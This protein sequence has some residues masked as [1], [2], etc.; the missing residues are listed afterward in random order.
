MKRILSL[1][2]GLC[3]VCP[4][5]HAT[6][7]KKQ[8]LKVLYVGGMTDTY[9]PAPEEKDALIKE[10]TEAFRQ[11]LD[12]YFTSV[13]AVDGNDYTADMSKQY[14]VTI[15]DGRP[16]PLKERDVIKDSQGNIVKYIPAKYLP[17]DFDCATVT[18]GQTGETVGRAIGLKNDWYCLCLDAQA[19]HW[20]KDHP[21]FKGPFKVKMTVETCPTP[22]DAYHYAYYHDGPIPDELPMWRV[23]T[24]GFKTDKGF[25][26]GMV[27]RPWGYTD[28]PDAEYISSGVCAKTLDAVAIGRHGNFLHWGFAASPL[29][30]TD[31]AKTVFANAVAYIAKFKGK[32]VQARK[33]NDRIATRE[34][35]KEIA[36]L[37][38][39]ASYDERMVSDREWHMERVKSYNA[40]IAKKAAGQELSDS[41]KEELKYGDPGE[42]KPRSREEYVKRYAKNFFDMFGTDEEAYAKYFKENYDY[43]YSEGFY[44]IFLD[45]DV[46]AWGIPNYNHRLLDKAITSLEQGNETD[47]AARILARYTMADFKTPAEWRKWYET[48]KD[49]MYFTEAGGWKFLIDGDA[50]IPGND[51]FEYQRR[52]AEKTSASTGSDTSDTNP[53]VTSVSVVNPNTE[54]PMLVVKFRIH[55]GYHIYAD[56]AGDDPYIPTRVNLEL[57]DGLSVGEWTITRPGP[58]GETGTTIHEGEAE[59]SCPLIGHG[60]GPIKCKV[61]YQVCDTHICMPPASKELHIR[62]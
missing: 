49:R 22:S 2:A 20:V 13:T 60:S 12:R 21:I 55:P 14:D 24:K 45:D 30:M 26:I 29:Y 58:F 4:A 54:K 34:Y 56:V 42:F 62:I 50:S 11:L 19:H 27:A 40:I 16:R 36:Y 33:F 44:N 43:F 1:I 59:Y 10:R 48:Y 35:L 38:T 28:S 53:V 41:E 61:S 39:K 6:A 18:I 47:R 31:E 3:L 17:D 57:P 46:K 32:T 25:A 15:L 9:Q 7:A 51:Y 23:Q 52:V 37:V 5:W 8:P